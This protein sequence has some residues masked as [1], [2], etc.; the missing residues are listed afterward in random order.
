MTSG[1][2]FI[3]AAGGEEIPNAGAE[4]QRSRQRRPAAS[5]PRPTRRRDAVLPPPVRPG[6]ALHRPGPRHRLGRPLGPAAPAVPAEVPGCRRREAGES[7]ATGRPPPGAPRAPRWAPDGPAADPRFSAA[8]PRFS[9]GDTPPHHRPIPR[10]RP[11]VP[12]AEPP[13]LP[14]RTHSRPAADPSGSPS[15]LSADLQFLAR[16][17]QCP[18]LSPPVACC[19]AQF[20][21]RSPGSLPGLSQRQAGQLRV[22]WGDTPPPTQPS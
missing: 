6:P 11:P 21:D 4:P 17:P 7:P 2:G 3:K 5:S 18:R 9:S 19:R 10:C 22:G 20:P 16:P 8:D 12:P 14:V 1:E 13:A 15:T